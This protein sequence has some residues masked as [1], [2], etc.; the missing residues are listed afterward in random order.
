[1]SQHSSRPVNK[2]LIMEYDVEQTGER[3]N[4]TDREEYQRE[5][6]ALMESGEVAAAVTVAFLK[7]NPGDPPT[8]LRLAVITDNADMDDARALVQ[9]A[10]QAVGLINRHKAEEAPAVPPERVIEAQGRL[11]EQW[12]RF[13]D[14]MDL[15]RAPP[16]LYALVRKSFYAGIATL[17]AELCA[18]GDSPDDATGA[19]DLVQQLTAEIHSFCFSEMLDEEPESRARH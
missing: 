14:A 3:K 18:A 19:R 6:K 5:Y 16:R 17:Y 10:A 15:D 2:G 11:A 7:A 12:L 8:A 13:A 1:M 4:L 9:Q